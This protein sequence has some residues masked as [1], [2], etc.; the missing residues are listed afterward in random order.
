MSSSERKKSIEL[1]EVIDLIGD[2]GLY[3]IVAVTLFIVAII[4]HSAVHNAFVFT[5][6]NLNYRCKIPEC[7][8][9]PPVYDAAFVAGAIPSNNLGPEKCETYLYNFSSL[10]EITCRPDEFDH[11]GTK[12]CNEFVYEMDAWSIL[13]EFHL[14]CE[15][16]E[17]KLTLVGTINGA[18]QLVGIFIGGLIADRF[19]R[20][21]VLIW[22][23]VLCAVFGLS[24][25]LVTTY[26]L[27][28]VF[29]F[30]DAFFGSSTYICGFVLGVELVGPKK[31][32]LTGILISS[33][34]AVG[35][36]VTALAAWVFKSWKPIIYAL[37]GP[38]LFLIVYIWVIPESV[39]WLLSK[40]RT[41]EAKVILRRAAKFNDKELS[42]STLEK[43]TSSAP[44]HSDG[45]HDS[46]LLALKSRVLLPRL[47][48]CA[49]CWMVC[50]FLFYG[51][52]LNSVSLADGN[53]YLDFILTSLIEI[54][55]YWC[56][57]FMLDLFGRRNS[58]F[59]SFLIT[60]VACAVHVFIPIGSYA[61]GLTMFLI[62]KFGATLAFTNVY[63]HTS[64]MFPTR[65]R[66]TFMGI[67]STLGRIG[68]ITAPQTP[69]LGRLWVHLP[70]VTFAVLA[71][72]AAALSFLFPE[73]ANIKLPDTIEEAENLSRLPK[74]APSEDQEKPSTA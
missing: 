13:Q 14:Q 39:R 61:G 43:L 70:M 54:P 24:R 8:T 46:L 22:G 38:S 25:T 67:C 3:Q 27:F 71:V 36:V 50:A 63:V 40:G 58:L 20:K 30:L 42:E 74:S 64:E 7:E 26:E 62:G 57:N 23:M 32:V 15:K 34:Y 16:N 19:G 33:S 53:P 35:E 2:F 9:S 68:S 11:S 45:N 12:K 37:Y 73:T 21:F 55:G 28:L 4:L 60:G 48:T 6:L 44:Q 49:F 59:A 18:G 69:L 17:W 52:T 1:D 31:R 47:L 41:E 56:S 72:A 29:E 51:F 5:A 65:M 10:E 66:Q